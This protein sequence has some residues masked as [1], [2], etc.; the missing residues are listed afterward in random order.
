MCTPSK[1]ARRL[2]DE[3]TELWPN[4]RRTSDGICSSADHRKR[5]PTSDHDTGDA[6]DVSHDPE[7]GCDAHGMA[8]EF[9]RRV[10]AGSPPP[11]ATRVKYIISD[12]EIW[13]PRVSPKWR[14]YRGSNPHTQ[15]AHWSLWMSQRNDDRDWWGPLL[16]VPK[17]PTTA[18]GEWW[19]MLA[20]NDLD[21]MRAY[22]RDAMWRYW[23]RG[24]R[25]VEELDMI[26]QH[27]L[28][29]GLDA[30]LILIVDDKKNKER[31]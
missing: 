28:K 31:K 2:L 4:R 22:V 17:E 23:H 12:R 24:P 1:A 7:N 11:G 29:R 19:M 21:G 27:G 14:P 13:N 30:A 16:L 10:V 3:A 15:H 5:N 9:V 8:R 25:S 26:A 18:E 6:G 20:K